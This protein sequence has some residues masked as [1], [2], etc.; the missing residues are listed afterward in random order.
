MIDDDK[1]IR[2]PDPIKEKSGRFPKGVSGNP[3]GR[4]V[5][6]QDRR[7]R[8]RGLIEDQGEALIQVMVKQALDGDSR[9][10]A[11]LASQLLPTPPRATLEAVEIPGLM[12]DATLSDIATATARAAAAGRL[13]PGHAAALVAVLRGAAELSEIADLRAAIEQLE[14]NR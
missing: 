2:L 12:P 10:Q 8:L 11:L 13:S 3:S 4:P 6:I 14:A 9:V 7:T 1:I 5:G